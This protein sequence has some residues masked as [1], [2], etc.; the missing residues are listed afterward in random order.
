MKYCLYYQYEYAACIGLFPLCQCNKKHGEVNVS[1]TDSLWLLSG[2]PSPLLFLRVA[3]PSALRGSLSPFSLCICN[4]WSPRSLLSYHVP[5]LLLL[6]SLQPPQSLPIKNE[7]LQPISGL[8]LE[9]LSVLSRDFKAPPEDRLCSHR[10][11][12][13]HSCRLHSFFRSTRFCFSAP[14]TSH[15][16]G[17]LCWVEFHQ[18][19]R[20]YLGKREE[21]D[22]DLTHISYKW[23]RK[24]SPGAGASA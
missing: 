13:W 10:E 8:N 4:H 5:C 11:L 24:P 14:K 2:D 20:V 19:P 23:V 6:V 17:T 7:E 1:P 3:L 21:I 16:Q 9:K 18:S 15:Y 22:A 12:P